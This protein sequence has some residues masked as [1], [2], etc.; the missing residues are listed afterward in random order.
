M[1]FPGGPQI[2]SVVLPCLNE[3]EAIG[4]LVAELTAEGFDEILVVDNGS[5]D[6]TAARARAAGA[7]VVSEPVPGYGRACARGV[8]SVRP[9]CTIVCFMDGDGSDIPAFLA[10]VVAV[11]AAD[12]ADFAMGS[13]VLGRREPGSM[14]VPQL[15]AGRIAGLLL[16]L[17]YGVR[18]TDMS[19]MRAMRLDLLRQLGMTEMTYG[20]NL[21]MQMRVAAAQLRTIELPVDHRCRRG[22]VSKVSGNLSAALR[23]AWKIAGTFLRLLHDLRPPSRHR[24]A[25]QSEGSP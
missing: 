1:R 24:A 7:T 3:E 18:V 5:T 9:D 10:S 22:G 21:E 14:S 2:V 19:P 25:V 8:A 20:W 4:P 13:R 6:A 15:V 12:K 23:A 11:I 16:R 17:A